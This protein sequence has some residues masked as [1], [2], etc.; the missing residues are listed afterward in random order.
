MPTVTVPLVRVDDA[1]VAWIEGTTTKVIEVARAK[2]AADL[3][4]EELQAELPHLS[5]AQVY[6]ALAYYHAHREEMDADI[7][8]RKRLVEEFRAE[9]KEPVS[10]SEL[11]ARL[12][13][14]E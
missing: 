13:P 7:Q 5:L 6:G 3:T 14:S 9:E 10:R 8:R 2:L 11:L 4:P 1:G 12:Q